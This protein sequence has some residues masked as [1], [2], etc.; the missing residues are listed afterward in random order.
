MALQTSRDTDSDNDGVPDSVEGNTTGGPDTDSVMA[1]QISAI[2]ILIM[3][4]FR[5]RVEGRHN[6]WPRLQ[7]V[8]APLIIRDTDAD[9]DGIP[10]SSRRRFTTGGPDTDSVMAHPDYLRYR[11]PGYGFRR[12]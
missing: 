8:M 3:T 12:F 5:T 10:D 11:C 9:N 4:V 6:W 1:R 2:P 7:T